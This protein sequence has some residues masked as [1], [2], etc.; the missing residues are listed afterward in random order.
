VGRP[1]I[2]AM[3]EVWYRLDIFRDGDKARCIACRS[4]VI[5]SASVQ[6][7]CEH[8][9]TSHRVNSGNSRF[10][11]HHC[12]ATADAD[13]MV[14]LS[15]PSTEILGG[16]LSRTPLRSGRLFGPQPS[17]GVEVS[18]DQ[19]WPHHC[20][21]VWLL[22]SRIPSRAIGASCHCIDRTVNSFTISIQGVRLP[23]L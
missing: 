7:R 21:G 9:W 11:T 18:N 8:C 22:T 16:V 12:H 23:L 15:S 2:D 5:Q 6:C 10:E 20:T 13:E 1:S 4:I 19:T 17:R 3:K 14:S